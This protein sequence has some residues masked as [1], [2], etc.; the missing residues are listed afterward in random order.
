V[1]ALDFREYELGPAIILRRE[2]DEVRL[3]HYLAQEGHRLTLD[4]RLDLIRQL[5]E[6]LKYADGR[7]VIHRALTPRS[8]LVTHCEKSLEYR[9]RTFMPHSPALILT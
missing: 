3:D 5:A 6:T 4:R 9:G 8:V 1:K 2:R 7:R